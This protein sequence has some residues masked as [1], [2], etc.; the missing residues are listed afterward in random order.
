[1]TML[2]DPRLTSLA[3]PAVDVLALVDGLTAAYAAIE[4]PV[5]L[6]RHAWDCSY[7]FEA[8]SPAIRRR[9][10]KALRTV[11]TQLR[12]ILSSPAAPVESRID[13]WDDGESLPVV[14]PRYT[15]RD[16]TS[17]R[18][19]AEAMRE[20]YLPTPEAIF[21]EAAIIRQGWDKY[22][23][24]KRLGGGPDDL[25]RRTGCDMDAEEKQRSAGG[26]KTSG[27]VFCDF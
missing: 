27:S 16:I 3:T 7:S 23:H 17:H 25:E 19:A 8:E 12:T 14:T 13:R 9:F 18:K 2:L 10:S 20:M 5:E 4:G 1:M 15:K 11:L 21:Q 24:R 22:E 6:V 26:I